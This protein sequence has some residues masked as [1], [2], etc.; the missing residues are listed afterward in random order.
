M[1]YLNCVVKYYHEK[2]DIAVIFDNMRLTYEELFAEAELCAEILKKNVPNQHLNIGLLLPNSIDYVK[3][4]L[5]ILLSGNIVVPIFSKA[6]DREVE[7]TIVACDLAALISYK[8]LD[9]KDIIENRCV[10]SINIKTMQIKLYGEDS[11]IVESQAPLKVKMMLSTSGSMN[12][13]KRVMLTY[14]NLFTNAQA[15]ID[16]LHY[17]KNEIIGVITP[18]CFSSGNTLLFTTLILGCTLVLYDGILMPGKLYDFLYRNKISTTTFVPSLLKLMV[19][20]DKFDSMNLPHLSTICFG[21]GPS[22]E[23]TIHKV[24]SKFNSCNVTHMYGQTEASPRITHMP[25][26]YMKWKNGSVGK[27]VPGVDLKIIDDNGN[28]IAC[29]CDGEVCVKG[30]NIFLGYYKQDILTSNA[31]RDGWLHT[32]DIGH[33]DSDGYLYITGRMK[34]VIIY[35]GMNIYPEEIETIIADMEGVQ[36]VIVYGESD[37]LT[38]ENVIADIVSNG[39]AITEQSII[40]Y[41]AQKLPPYKIPRKYNFVDAIRRTNNGKILRK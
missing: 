29:N 19:D 17:N 13:P 41:C 2:N 36:D 32:G 14:E 34:N 15:V 6:T 25:L 37:D 11:D 35:C 24:L 1:D 21:G 20:Y 22:S 23:D 8:D 38:G 12:D 27:T 7:N 5:G 39:I 30:K 3:W 10:K 4:F 33:L 31:I 16:G 9:L 18:L 28:E 40:A 26:K